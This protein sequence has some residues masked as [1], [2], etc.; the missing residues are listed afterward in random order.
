[1]CLISGSSIFLPFAPNRRNECGGKVRRKIISRSR[2]HYVLRGC[3][4]GGDLR[5]WRL[6]LDFA[7]LKKEGAAA[8]H[9][10]GDRRAYR[11]TGR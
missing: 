6:W 3:F 2:Q 5:I 10:G 8:G 4:G 11:Q 9:N 7:D 1:M